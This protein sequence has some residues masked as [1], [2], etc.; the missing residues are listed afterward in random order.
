MP[1][2][3]VKIPFVKSMALTEDFY[4]A[5]AFNAIPVAKMGRDSL[6]A[7]MPSVAPTPL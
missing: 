7:Y 4:P 5:G 2:D 1:V 6:I 3:L